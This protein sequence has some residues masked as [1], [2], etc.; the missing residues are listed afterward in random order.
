MSLLLLGVG[1]ASLPSSQYLTYGGDTTNVATGASYTFAGVNLGISDA[2]RLIVVGVHTGSF[3]HDLVTVAG[4]NASAVGTAANTVA[5]FWR[6]WSYQLGAGVTSGDITVR[7]AGTSITRCGIGVWALYPTSATPRDSGNDNA[8]STTDAVVPDLDVAS[9]GTVI[10][11]GGQQS[12]VDGVTVTWN[13]TDSVTQDFQNTLEAAARIAGGRI[14]ITETNSTRDLTL[15][16][17]TSGTKVL[18]AAS[19]DA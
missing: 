9:G 1:G 4:N 10:W 2:K 5:G 17:T 19:W 8:S 11:F 12:V 18:V 3:D 13:G 7:S 14:A 6:L 15:A 16:E